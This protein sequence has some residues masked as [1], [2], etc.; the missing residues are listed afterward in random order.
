MGRNQKIGE[1]KKIVI[2][3]ADKGGGLVVQKKT[4]YINKLLQFW[5]TK[6]HM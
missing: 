4:E 1:E 2:R 5:G 3:P 6:T